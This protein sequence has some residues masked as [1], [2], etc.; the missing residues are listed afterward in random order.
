ML[1]HADSRQLA[2]ANDCTNVTQ[3]PTG[4]SELQ[5]WFSL[6]IFLQIGLLLNKE[7]F[8]IVVSK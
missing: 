5:G 1:S 6:L 2:R 3:E 4:G 7:A 8:F